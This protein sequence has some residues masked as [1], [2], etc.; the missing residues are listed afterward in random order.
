MGGLA[1]WVG[2]L[3]IGPRVGLF[4]ADRELSYILDDDKFIKQEAE[5][6]RSFHD[7]HGH[8]ENPVVFH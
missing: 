8:D 1:G 2:T 6:D 4:K 7:D 3:L 5:Y